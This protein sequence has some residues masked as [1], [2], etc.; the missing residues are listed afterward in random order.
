MHYVH[1]V[2]ALE[3]SGTAQQRF[4]GNCKP[5]AAFFPAHHTVS[6]LSTLFSMELWKA[7]RHTQA[8]AAADSMPNP[9]GHGGGQWRGRKKI[10]WERGVQAVSTQHQE[11]GL[12][13]R[14]PG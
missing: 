11:H 7:A 9:T 5:K 12:Q 1:A 3:S 10:S 8:V 13:H 6:S 4:L 2:H 14:W